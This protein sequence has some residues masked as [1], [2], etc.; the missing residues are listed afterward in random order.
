MKIFVIIAV[1]VLFIAALFVFNSKTSN[2]PTESSITDSPSGT[3][4]SPS[5]SVSPKVSAKK[6]EIII[7]DAGLSTSDLKIKVGDTVTF[8][9][10]SSVLVWPATGPHPIH[11]VCPGF[12]A[13]AGLG[14]NQTYTHTFTTAKTCTFHDHLHASRAEYRGQIVVT[15]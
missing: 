9:N 6:H 2:A 1:I 15:P 4:T 7:T 8:V 5:S 11:T 12:D 3:N 10:K 13:L 14:L